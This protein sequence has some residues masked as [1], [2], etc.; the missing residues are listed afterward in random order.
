MTS[1]SRIAQ[2]SSCSTQLQCRRYVARFACRSACSGTATTLGTAQWCRFFDLRSGTCAVGGCCSGP[3]QFLFCLFLVF[4]FLFFFCFLSCIDLFACRK[5]APHTPVTHSRVPQCGVRARLTDLVLIGRCFGTAGRKRAQLV[6]V[7]ELL[8]LYVTA[9]ALHAA[10]TSG[11]CRPLFGAPPSHEALCPRCACY[12]EPGPPQA[13][14]LHPERPKLRS[15]GTNTAGICFLRFSSCQ[16]QQ[17]QPPQ[18]EATENNDGHATP[19]QTK[20]KLLNAGESVFCCMS[21]LTPGCSAL[22]WASAT[23]HN[24]FTLINLEK[25][26]GGR[27]NIK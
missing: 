4:F 8:D 24:L 6:H 9:L 22:S 27:R 12:F 7:V 5:M 10:N 25:E 3:R 16:F 14:P 1:S 19:N 23:L 11:N 18:L 15:S 20:Q 2:A 26:S 17:E 13:H 21:A